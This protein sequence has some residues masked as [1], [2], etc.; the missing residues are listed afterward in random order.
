M[1][2]EETP[3]SHH[4][5]LMPPGTREFTFRAVLAGVLVAALIGG[6]YPY[7]V[8][9]IGYGPNPSIVSAIFGYLVLG[10]M[11]KN[12]QRWENN[13]VQTAGT[14]AGATAFMCVL[15]AAFDMLNMDPSLNF[16]FSIS[17]FQSFIWL[18]TAGCLGVLMAVPMRK[19]FIIDEK[20]PFV[21]GMA[22]AE[23]LTVL[24]SKGS[25]ARGSAYAMG[26]GSV[27]S[28]ILTVLREDSRLLT[29]VWYRIP[30]ILPI[31]Q[32]GSKLNF[33]VSWSLLPIG[34]GMLLGLRVTASMILGTIISWYVIPPMLLEHHIVTEL[35]RR[36]VLLWVMWPGTGLLIAGGI[37][38]LL[39]RWSVLMKTFQN[40]S[41]SS[42]DA[43]DF[44]LS[45]VIWGSILSGLALIAFQ[46]TILGIP[47]W[48]TVIAIL[49]SIPLMLVGLRV[50]GETNFQAIS[51]LSNMMQVVF[52]VIAPG[53]I[54]A[55]MV[56]SGVTGTIASESEGL[57][58]DFKTG[59]M[60]GSTP[61]YLT[62]VQLITIPVGAAA[63]SYVYPL[64][65]A[66]Y[67]IGGEHG[68]QS[69]I[70]QKWASF[71]QILSKGVSG[72]PNG[73]IAAMAIAIVCGVLLTVLGSTRF[74][75]YTPSPT[76]IGIGMLVPG[77]LIITMFFG[78]VLDYFWTKAHPRSRQSYVIPLAS[79]F[80]AGEAIIAVVI[81][82]LATIGIIHLLP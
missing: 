20:L 3:I 76:G 30:E 36:Q 38:V 71:A 17:P 45:W 26:W 13:M 1:T 41:L 54:A 69:P 29:N 32:F 72:L 77:S 57:M 67:G 66:T 34:S 5:Q 68:L 49:L 48:M 18:T 12:S 46:K 63:V 58:Q 52:G 59:D 4:S 47:V 7:V 60:I 79:G 53:H 15:L 43:G 23:T 31:G 19:H 2:K 24:D 73:A 65:R 51:M 14:S 25:E 62:Y 35:T 27:L 22:V 28:G 74:K 81:P 8:M 11:F 61:R 78:A 56:S 80:I 21:D 42:I 50:Q 64:L 70:S 9:K 39:M 10:L 40:L 33:G 37:T 75:L 16:N 55:N 44:P 82:I 6:S